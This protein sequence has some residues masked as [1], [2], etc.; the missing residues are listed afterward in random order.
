[1]GRRKRHRPDL[2]R[3][4]GI[5]MRKGPS[6]WRMDATP[7]DTG[8]YLGNLLGDDTILVALF[9]DGVARVRIRTIGP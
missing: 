9:D 7:D 3:V 6:G 2:R 8:A 4:G 1:M 5:L